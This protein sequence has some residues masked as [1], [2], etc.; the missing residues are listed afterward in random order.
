VK[1]SMIYTALAVLA[2]ST[3][4]AAQGYPPSGPPGAMAP[5]EIIAMLRSTGFDP[6][7]QPIRRGPN[8]LLRAIDER[9]REVNLVISARSGD[10]LSVTPM[11]TASR[12]P[13]TSP[14]VTMGPYE[15]MPPGYIP[16]G[17]P[18]GYGAPITDDDDEAL[19]PPGFGYN[20]PRPP[21]AMPGSPLPRSSNAAPPP[22]G[23]SVQP[24]DDDDEV[25]PSSRSSNSSGAPN[26]IPADPD[27]GG[28]LPPPPERFPQRAAP[29]APPKPKSVTRA[30][31]AP[32]NA[33]PAASKAAPIPKPKPGTTAAA[34]PA[35]A[36]PAWPST[37]AQAPMPVPAKSAPAEAP[38]KSAPAEETPH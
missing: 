25:A 17:G 32:P 11:Q 16:P 27:R 7:G 13:P 5:Y 8:Y 4:A 14:G 12:I 19:P 23:G 3:P 28:L 29:A 38:A 1:R 34:P 20:A 37:P 24:Y 35:S 18:R 22:R 10:I 15:R 30:A 9:D 2:L 6:I 26:V 31:V 33:P 36:Q 21:G